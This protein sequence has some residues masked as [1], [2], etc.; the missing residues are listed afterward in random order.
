LSLA[1]VIAYPST[2]PASYRDFHDRHP[3]QTKPNP[4]PNLDTLLYPL[5][6]A[7]V[8]ST[9][10]LN[11]VITRSLAPSYSIT[12]DILGNWCVASAVSILQHD[13]SKPGNVT[14]HS[15]ILLLNGYL[16]FDKVTNTWIAFLYTMHGM[17]R[18]N[19]QVFL[20][21]DRHVNSPQGSP[22]HL[23]IQAANWFLSVSSPWLCSC[24][25][26][27]LKPYS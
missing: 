25:V 13:R 3:N 16:A 22:R 17:R 18:N 20:T 6:F 11:A 24:E 2:G 7:T 27:A 12:L 4:L 14:F 10:R 5:R 19:R 21:H 9:V 23:E 15:S 26:N 1:P 8:Y